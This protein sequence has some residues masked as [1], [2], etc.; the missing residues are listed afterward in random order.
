MIR[1]LLSTKFRNSKLMR[2]IFYPIR[3]LYDFVLLKKYQKS[4][5]S[6][7][8][9]G[10]CGIHNNK[11]CFIIGNGPSLTPDDLDKIKNEISFASNRIYHIFQFTE[12]RPNYYLSMDFNVIA[13]EIE[14]IKNIG[15]Y[16]K[17]INY[18]A[19]KYG[20]KSDSNL[21]YIFMKG[22]FNINPFASF[23]NELS[24]DASKYLTK[25]G[26]VT[27]T[28]IELAIYMGFKEIYLLGVDNNYAIKVDKKGRIYNDPTV[29]SSYFKGMKDSSGKLGDGFSVQSVETANNSYEMCKKFAEEKGVRIY[30]ATRGGKLEVFE[31]IDFDSI[32]N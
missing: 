25:S 5:D 28:A 30:N 10:L 2:F 26:T 14:N 23:A 11:R 27:A 1:E 16:P 7:Y 18:R 21:W 32:F 20:R 3:C 15:N 6:K 12:W 29:K 9:Q 8:I 22:K 24:N 13:L 17:F 19:A 31:R 4:D